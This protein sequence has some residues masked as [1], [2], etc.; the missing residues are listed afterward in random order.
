M[1]RGDVTMDTTIDTENFDWADNIIFGKPSEWPTVTND[2]EEYNILGIDP[3]LTFLLQTEDTEGAAPKPV[4]EEVYEKT[5]QDT[6]L[7]EEET[8]TYTRDGEVKTYTTLQTTGTQ[9]LLEIVNIE[10]FLLD[11]EATEKLKEELDP[12]SSKTQQEPIMA[13]STVMMG[14]EEKLEKKKPRLKRTLNTKEV[15]QEEERKKTRMTHQHSHRTRVRP[16]QEEPRK[17]TTGSPQRNNPRDTDKQGGGK[18]ASYMQLRDP[19]TKRTT[20]REEIKATA[21]IRAVEAKQELRKRGWPPQTGTLN[22]PTQREAHSQQGRKP[23]LMVPPNQEYFAKTMS[24]ETIH[25]LR[26]LIAKYPTVCGNLGKGDLQPTA[27]SAIS[28]PDDGKIHSYLVMDNVWQEAIQISTGTHFSHFLRLET[29]LENCKTRKWT[30]NIEASHFFHCQTH[31]QGGK[32]TVDS[33]PVG[34]WQNP[35]YNPLQ[36]L[37]LQAGTLARMQSTEM[38]WGWI[39]RKLAD[40]TKPSKGEKQQILVGEILDL[41]DSWPQLQVGAEGVLTYQKQGGGGNRLPCIPRGLTHLL[42]TELHYQRHE[43][44]TELMRKARSIG[45]FC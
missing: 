14:T 37:N 21:T 11:V 33:S 13:D 42:I 25:H 41:A 5:P 30:V 2:V 43:A 1:N 38:E 15:P 19:P 20:E 45:V 24:M 18:P 16:P 17:R 40:A 7:M 34:T 23:S 26:T 22:N 36:T 27:Q 44:L 9:E 3:G 8:R 12:G 31:K 10:E 28:R 39:K 32:G 6:E 29:I 35:D 4:T